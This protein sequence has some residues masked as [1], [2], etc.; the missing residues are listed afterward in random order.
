MG[1]EFESES[2]GVPGLG[3]KPPTAR[4]TDNSLTRQGAEGKGGQFTVRNQKEEKGRDGTHSGRGETPER[5]DG[6]VPLPSPRADVRPHLYF[7][8]ILQ[9]RFRRLWL[10]FPLENGTLYLGKE[11]IVQFVSLENGQLPVRL[12]KVF[13]LL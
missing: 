3:F 2:A 11:D 10:Q 5:R 4:F 9:Q 8:V 7:G 12:G 6:E 13:L 1:Q